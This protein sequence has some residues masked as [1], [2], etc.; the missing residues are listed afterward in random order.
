MQALPEQ[1]RSEAGP[2]DQS[3][4][5][6]FALAVRA[7]GGRVLREID[8]PARDHLIGRDPICDVIIP[9]LEAD[10]LGILHLDERDGARIV[11][12]TAFVAGL[13][14][15]SR[16]LRIGQRMVLGDHANLRHSGIE[17]VVRSTRPT[18]FGSS[19]HARPLLA[20]AL[21]ALLAA[22]AALI[23]QDRGQGRGVEPAPAS[24][25]G[26]PAYE[27]PGALL[28]NAEGELRRRLRIAGLDQALSVS[29]DG[30][31]LLLRGRLEDDER[32]RLMDLLAGA[33]TAIR[34]P[35][36]VELTSSLQQAA[37]VVA[38]VIEPQAYI[39]TRGGARLRAGQELQ[40]GI[41]IQSIEANGILV[42]RD[43][44]RERIMLAR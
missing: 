12:F 15:D 26:E 3:G 39:L 23:G 44:L 34:V 9:D 13:S 11:G 6:L 41:V 18:I 10:E 22:F 36:D 16:V 31:R 38:V 32:P 24:A 1:E 20:L 2:S 37:L 27:E 43:G 29:S 19:R 7:A 40:P 28:R 14:S 33:R 4:E 17:L 35:I 5:A 25:V 30:L 8:L 42:R 21:S